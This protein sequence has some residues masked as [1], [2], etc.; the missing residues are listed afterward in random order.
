[1]KIHTLAITV[2]VLA[3]MLPA[4]RPAAPTNASDKPTDAAWTPPPADNTKSADANTAP[5]PPRALASHIAEWIEIGLTEEQI[6]A[7]ATE[8]VEN[9]QLGGATGL[10]DAEKEMLKKAGA[11]DELITWAAALDL[12]EAAPAP[13]KKEGEEAAPPAEGEKAEGDKPAGDSAPPAAEAAPKK[14]E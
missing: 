11:T 7:K 14:A 12:P 1:M 5:D 4:C 6:R 3:L 9:D 13:E 10:T 2:I 8:G